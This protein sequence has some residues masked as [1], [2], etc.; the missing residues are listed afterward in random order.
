M[1]LIIHN[2]DDYLSFFPL[3]LQ[4]S[5]MVPASECT[6]RIEQVRSAMAAQVQAATEDRQAIQA[7]AESL[8]DRVVSLEREAH[9]TLGRLHGVL[10]ALSAASEA[11]HI[12]YEH[13]SM[14]LSQSRSKKARG[15]PARADLH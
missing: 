12:G 6:T 8:T 13:K 5:D 15:T 14:E 11:R 10:S 9:S 3:H 7:R 2:V 4:M 1:H